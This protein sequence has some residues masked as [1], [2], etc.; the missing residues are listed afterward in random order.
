MKRA[1]SV[2]ILLIFVFACSAAA[3]TAG[4]NRNASDGGVHGIAA[5]TADKNQ[6]AFDSGNAAPQARTAREVI[7]E[8]AKKES[9]EES[10]AYIAA[11]IGA[12]SAPQEKRAL[13]AFLG[14]LQEHM[15]RFDDARKSY[16]AAAAISA[17]DAAGMQKKSSEQLVLDAVR[18]ALSTGNYTTADSYLN[19]AVRNTSD[20]TIQAHIK[21]YALWSQLC[22]ANVSADLDESVVMLKAYASLGSMKSVKPSVLLT[23]WYI[24]G[25]TAWAELLKKDF[26]SSLETGIV[27]GDVQLL[28]APFWY[29]LPRN[30]ATVPKVDS[31]V[32]IAENGTSMAQEQTGAA[33]A[34]STSSGAQSN[35]EQR[36]SQQANGSL[37]KRTLQL[38]LFREK[39]NADKLVATLKEKGFSAYITSE[40]RASG[41]TYYLVLIDETDSSIGDTLRTAGFEFYPL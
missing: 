2:S 36:T 24:T 14:S 4:A 7:N 6:S 41:T 10:A 28:P 26:P 16:A 32:E 38:G 30:E 17:G 20:E 15:A 23:L 9:A 19:S 5:Q 29:F 25:E 22:R 3:Q 1:Y 18:C 37:Q 31:R 34:A 33:S 39:A 12:I 27:Q 21:L 35:A 8:A 11:C 13:Y 40:T